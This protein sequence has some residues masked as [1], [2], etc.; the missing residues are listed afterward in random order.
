LTELDVWLTDLFTYL[1]DKCWLID[2]VY[3]FAY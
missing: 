1:L 3:L 2:V